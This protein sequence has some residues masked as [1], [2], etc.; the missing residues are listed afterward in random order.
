MI[1][2]DRTM[3]L[4]RSLLCTQLV[5]LAGEQRVLVI[6]HSDLWERPEVVAHRCGLP[7]CLAAGN[8]GEGALAGTA[9]MKTRGAQGHHQS[10]PGDEA[11]HRLDAELAPTLRAASRRTS[12]SLTTS[13]L[14]VT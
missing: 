12:S 7:T 2:T 9:G 3:S 4:F 13:T 11:S 8:V 10:R 1:T 6:S 14:T 5:A